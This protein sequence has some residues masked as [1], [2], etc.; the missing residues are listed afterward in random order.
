MPEVRALVPYDLASKWQCWDLNLTLE[1]MVLSS[2]PLH[3]EA[4]THSP[5]SS[6][7]VCLALAHPSAD[8][9]HHHHGAESHEGASSSSWEME[10]N[11]KF[12]F[13]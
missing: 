8:P 3:G 9:Q 10:S 11:E 1:N 13:V 12:L 4:R 2:L 5:A 7:N 6:E